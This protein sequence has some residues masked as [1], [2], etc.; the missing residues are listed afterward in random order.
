MSYQSPDYSELNGALTSHKL[1]DQT[2]PA[3]YVVQPQVVFNY[4]GRSRR[5]RSTCSKCCTV[6]A[7]LLG[8]ISALGS[9]AIVVLR[10]YPNWYNYQGYTFEGH[11]MPPPIEWPEWAVWLPTAVTGAYLLLLLIFTC[12]RKQ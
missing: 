1:Y 12:C 6:F 3:N 2:H 10:Y 7:W 4:D 5:R 8:I 9:A 11:Y